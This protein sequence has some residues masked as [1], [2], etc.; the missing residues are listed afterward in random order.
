MEQ[1]NANEKIEGKPRK[2]S[3]SCLVCLLCFATGFTLSLIGYTPFPLHT[4]PIE[5]TVVILDEHGEAIPFQPTTVTVFARYASGFLRSKWQTHNFSVDES[6]KFS[7]KI[8]EFAATLVFT[9]K[10]GKYAAVVDI[11]PDMPPTGLT[12]E[13]R[14]RYTV[15]GRLI[16]YDGT[17]LASQ[18]IRLSY[19]RF[20]D[21]EKNLSFRITGRQSATVKELHTETTTTD[22]EGFF[23]I[24]N[25]IPGIEYNLR[26]AWSVWNTR[27]E[28]D[29]WVPS[30]EM[31]FLEPEQ[32]QE[33]FDLGDV[34]VR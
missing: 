28:H 30:L 2:R 12:I 26:N 1:E 20:G 31:P 19:M 10:D 4:M 6:G 21:F 15:T 25:V 3:Q 7:R 29:F 34:S 18:R 27:E 33:P 23:T 16:H 11:T 14:P 13:L 32:Y 9:T 5:G 22:S 24:N 8:P 17:P